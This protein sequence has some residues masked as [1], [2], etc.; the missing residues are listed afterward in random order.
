MP[1]PTLAA[2][3][4]PPVIAAHAAAEAMVEAL[5]L[6][7]MIAGDLSLFGVEAALYAALQPRATSP[8][9][10]RF[11][12]SLLAE[13]LRREDASAYA[14]ALLAAVSAD[15]DTMTAAG[16]HAAPPPPQS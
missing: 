5:T 6:D 3:G 11:R 7:D 2:T 12:L 9:E 4:N 16:H 1:P 14:C 15:F 10:V 13:T 8:I